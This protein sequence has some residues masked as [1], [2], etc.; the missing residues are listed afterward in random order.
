MSRPTGGFIRNCWYVAG[1]A[2]EVGATTPLARRLLGEPVVL[3]RTAEGT[4]VALRDACAHRLAP[5]SA[6]RVEAHGLRCLYHG[7][8][9]D[10]Q[11][12]AVEV[13]GQPQVPPQLRVPSYPLVER[14]NLLWI[15][16]GDPALADASRIPHIPAL[17]DPAWPMKPGTMHFRAH[18]Q[19]VLDNLL[20]FSHLSYVHPGT[21]GGTTQIAMARPRVERTAEGVHIER[22][23]FDVP[24][25]PFQARVGGFAGNVDRWHRYDVLLPGLMIMESGVQPTGTGAVEGRHEGALRFRPVNLVTPE[26]ATT[27]HYFYALPHDFAL[28]DEA[29][30]EQ[31]FAD[32]TQA[33][34]E[35]RVI[36]EAQQR[37][38]DDLAATGAVP[39]MA[40]LA[41]DT[42]LGHLRWMIERRL[43]A[44][45]L[46]PVAG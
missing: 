26:S 11:G 4:P 12:V 35:D 7:V 22:W 3:F 2:H 46:Q 5:L 20:D 33:F 32:L 17:D 13:P 23:V 6:G 41:A 25:A 18:Y 27:T 29:V 30:N 16:M 1:W 24:A 38:I 14:D 28:G 43:Q 44:E 37:V 19:L 8:V 36:I 39:P 42:A 21:V 34:D 10:A 31:L 45:A 15:W 9:F 40:A